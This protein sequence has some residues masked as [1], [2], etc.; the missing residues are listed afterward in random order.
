VKNCDVQNLV[1]VGGGH[2]HVFVLK[3]LGM[4]PLNGLQVTLITR[5]ILTP[6]RRGSYSAIA[7][8]IMLVYQVGWTSLALA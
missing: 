8:V 2:S 4:K 1:L 6:Y 3:S 7:V 5:D